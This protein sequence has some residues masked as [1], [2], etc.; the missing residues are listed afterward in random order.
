MAC[1]SPRVS[2]KESDIDD[3]ISSRALWASPGAPSGSAA[4]GLLDV[5][6]SGV[7]LEE[8]VEDARLMSNS[9][10]GAVDG[11]EPAEALSSGG[12]RAGG[13]GAGPDGVGRT[14]NPF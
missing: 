4:N 10:A 1:S 14:T 5:G 11:T 6:D 7:V 9:K 3:G 2:I 12:T 8:G 13:L